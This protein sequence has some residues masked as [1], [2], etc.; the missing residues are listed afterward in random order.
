MLGTVRDELC[1]SMS[2]FLFFFDFFY[3]H[4]TDSVYGRVF[5]SVLASVVYRG[6]NVS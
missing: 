4:K 5:L 1:L 3:L 2:S 6:I